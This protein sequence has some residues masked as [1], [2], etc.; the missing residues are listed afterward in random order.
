MK[1]LSPN[2]FLLCAIASASLLLCATYADAREPQ[3]KLD[4]GKAFQT[5][6]SAKDAMVPLSETEEINLGQGVTSNLLSLAPLVDDVEVQ[7]YVNKVG[8]WVSMHSERPDLPWT[9]VVL[10]YPE[11]NAF[12]APGGYVVIT[13]GLL[14][15]LRNEAE[16]AGVL[17][18][19]IGHVVRKHHL[20]AI[21]K[22][23]MKSFTEGGAGMLMDARGGGQSGRNA[24]ALFS[25]ASELYGKG[26]DKEDEFDADRVG[27]VLAA[28]AGYDP[29]GLPAA[30]QTLQANTGDSGSLKLL[31][32][33]HP[34]PGDRLSSLE[35]VMDKS[36][37]RF[38][39]SPDLKERFAKILA[40]LSV[41]K[42]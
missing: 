42:K 2:K 7:Q 24:L 18:H 9:F 25:S 13:S 16:L 3:F 29:Y 27:V 10:N 40:R 8:R 4:L 30:L 34:K 22:A 6:K 33:T 41:D 17:A 35:K 21:Q 20:A 19:E 39:N 38:E 28:R 15:K 1:N 12:A 36:F 37:E 23:N 31:L 11:I 32:E 14:M 5:I 26:L